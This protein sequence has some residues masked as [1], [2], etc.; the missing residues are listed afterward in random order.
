MNNEKQF[1]I[2]DGT[3]TI[4]KP[5]APHLFCDMDEVV[6]A[7]Y[8]EYEVYGRK[9]NRVLN[10][11]DTDGNPDLFA[12]AV[13]EHKI[14]SNIKP[15]EG[16]FKLRDVLLSIQQEHQIGISFLSSLNSNNK[17]VI[18]EAARQKTEWL[19][20][21]GFPWSPIFVTHHSLKQLFGNHNTLLIDDNPKCVDP[22]IEKNGKGILYT[23]FNEEFITELNEKLETIKV[24]NVA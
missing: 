9:N 15:K 3:S 10:H 5:Y 19:I 11:N 2:Y 20:K 8:A 4:T 7:F 21:H 12:K 1:L 17:E 6:A 13:L 18:L 16:A 14:F 22:F 23:K 24:P